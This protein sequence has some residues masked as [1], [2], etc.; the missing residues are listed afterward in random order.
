M[1][2][3]QQRV[4]TYPLEIAPRASEPFYICD[5]ASFQSGAEQFLGVN[6]SF[7]DRLRFRFIRAWVE[8]DDGKM[9]RVKLSK[10]VRD[11]WRSAARVRSTPENKRG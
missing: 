11:I 2:V 8:T 9:F 1:L 10:E 4:R 3:Q 7:L 5:R 6:N